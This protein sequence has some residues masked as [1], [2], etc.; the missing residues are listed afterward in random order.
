MSQASKVRHLALLLA[1]AGSYDAA[2]ANSAG[3]IAAEPLQEVRTAAEEAVRAQLQGT[4]HRVH[5]QA[6]QLD[7]RLRLARCPQPLSTQIA[8]PELS[9]HVTVRVGCAAHEAAWT[10]F[11]PVALESE[12]PVLVLRQNETRGARVPA[13]AVLTET[14]RIQGMGSEYVSDLSLLT[15]RTLV[16][17]VAA[18]TALTGALF[19]ADYLVRQGQSVTLVAAAPGI[20]VR[21]PATALEDGREGGRVRV[22]NLASQRVVQ[23]VVDA[24]GLIY[25]TP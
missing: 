9:A 13:D 19:Q 21:A 23:G 6:T 3:V 17:D 25:V 12:I 15:H 7:P 14:R 20:E 16:R 5:V 1:L 2:G 18:G 11:V 10:V 22:Q 8:A 24:N 4:A